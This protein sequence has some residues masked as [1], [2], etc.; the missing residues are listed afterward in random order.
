VKSVTGGLPESLARRLTNLSQGECI[1]TGQMNRLPFAVLVKGKYPRDLVK[2]HRLPCAHIAK[3]IDALTTDV[4]GWYF[5]APKEIN[6]E[7]IEEMEQGTRAKIEKNVPADLTNVT[8][9]L[10]IKHFSE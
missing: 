6:Q 7:L 2:T 9:D 8:P 1:I 10:I 4:E 5:A 3:Q